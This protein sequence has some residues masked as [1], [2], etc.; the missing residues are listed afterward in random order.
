MAAGLLGVAAGYSWWVGTTTPFTAGADLATSVGF[1]LMA[2]PAVLTYRRRYL[3]RPATTV[4]LDPAEHDTS[5]EIARRGNVTAWVVVISLITALEVVGYFGGSRY[6]YP[7]L[8]SLY[9]SASGTV[10]GKAV[11]A[12][13]WVLLGWGLFRR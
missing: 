10:A 4:S 12:F 3:H 6:S 7:T 5:T 13:L 1:A 11:F 8:S 2:V 9:N